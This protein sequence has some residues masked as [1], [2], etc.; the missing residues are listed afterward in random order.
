[1]NVNKHILFIKST[2]TL[3][4]ISYENVLDKI[5][6]LEG[7]VP[8]QI[9][10]IEYLKEKKNVNTDIYKNI[11]DRNPE[12]ICKE[13]KEEISKI[14][15]KVPLYDAKAEN[16]FLID[17]YDVYNRVTRQ[18][19]RFPEEQLLEQLIEEGKEIE[20]NNKDDI[21]KLRKLRKIKLI[22]EFLGQFDLQIL[23][24]TYVRV[25][26]KYSD[27]GGKELT[28]CKKKSF[29]P[30]FIH[31]EPYYTKNEIINMAFNLGYGNKDT[32]FTEKELRN[33]CKIVKDNEIS[34][35]TLLKHQN[36][37]SKNNYVGLV[38]YYTLQGS[39]F[40]NQYLRKLCDYKYKNKVLEDIISSMW[41]LVLTS[42]EFDH[43]YFFYR[44]MHSDNHIRHLNVGDVYI[45]NGFMSTTRDPFYRADL[46][47][48]GFILLKISVPSDK[49]GVALCL[50]TISHFA[51]EEEIIFPPK[52]KFKLINKDNNVAYYH[53]DSD[54][55]SKVKV[56]YEFEW[57]GNEEVTFDERPIYKDNNVIDFLKLKKS[58][59]SKLDDRVKNFVM[60]NVN[61][62][63]QFQINI[64]ELELTAIAEHF[65]ST[66]AYKPF[67]MLESN[68]G[69]SLYAF[70][71]KYILF[72]IEIGESE[73]MGEVMHVNFYF[74]LYLKNTDFEASKIMDDKNFIY[75]IS[76]VAYHFE[77]PT[78]VIY[79][80]YKSCHSTKKY[81]LGRLNIKQRGFSGNIKE[82]EEMNEP[83]N[84]NNDFMGSYC[85]DIYE[86]LAKGIKKYEDVDILN[87]E[88]RPRYSYYYLDALRK[89]SPS[90]V[91][92]KSAR[93]ECYQVYQ[94]IYIP[95]NKDKDTICDFFIWLKENKCY[96]LPVLIVNLLAIF[97]DVD[98]PFFNDYYLFDSAAYLYN[99]K[100]INSY[101]EYANKIAIKK[102]SNENNKN[103][104][105]L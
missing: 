13:I 67:Y 69:F 104:Y 2:N 15:E 53:T 29:L 32:K 79:A 39:Y 68:N 81:Q 51:S 54:F 72:F 62:L 75:F 22:M 65:D 98:N 82:D 9:D 95:N 101:P 24:D 58:T 21:L 12:E 85:V 37:I 100:Y 10:I 31:I 42:P 84:S 3:E 16:I 89:I 77:I 59:S 43:T 25:F 5:Y 92:R 44:F 64:G 76:T 96:L 34:S 87:M 93:D 11:K 86:Y 48:F 27:V 36:H 50:E 20:N 23:F 8:K 28:L 105:R 14:E 74:N 17:K 78:V 83:N 55:L 63:Y 94:K 41:N 91:L 47:K 60:N 70:H 61:P 102:N 80:D 103:Y 52:T 57:I 6:F 66:T 4:Y 71:D 30:Q 40:I 1:M 46:Y 18:T 49:K 7:T 26:Y 99:R 19:F 73:K 90:K 88:L 35:A 56:R 45:E 33:L 97:R 38:Q